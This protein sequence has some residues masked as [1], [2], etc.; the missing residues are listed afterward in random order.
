MDG[1]WV[2]VVRKLLRWAVPLPHIPRGCRSLQAVLPTPTCPAQL[3]PRHGPALGAVFFE[4]QSELRGVKW[5]ALLCSQIWAKVFKD[6]GKTI[7]QES[8]A[9]VLLP[10]FLFISIDF[11]PKVDGCVPQLTSGLRTRRA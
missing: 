2:V 11:T 4:R 6:I 5:P 7:G 8:L 10:L 3:P 1:Q 9:A